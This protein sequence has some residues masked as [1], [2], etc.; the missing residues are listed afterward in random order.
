M[1]ELLDYAYRVEESSVSPADLLPLYKEINELF[2]GGYYETFDEF[3]TK[4][5]FTQT[6]PV[7]MIG[8]I[9]LSFSARYKLENWEDATYRV[10]DELLSRGM[11]AATLLRGLMSEFAVKFPPETVALAQAVAAMPEENLSPEE[12][13]EWARKLA[14]DI[15]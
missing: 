13:E 9:R 12:I 10:Y 15:T 2:Q 6:A 5:D 4:I 3:L 14:I 8:I 7:V 1:Q 11:E